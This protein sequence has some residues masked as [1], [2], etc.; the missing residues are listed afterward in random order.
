MVEL[1]LM[2]HERKLL[3]WRLIKNPYECK[4]NV[5]KKKLF[6]YKEDVFDISNVA[7][8]EDIRNCYSE[9]QCK[10]IEND[11]I[12]VPFVNKETYKHCLRLYKNEGDT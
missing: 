12:P 6:E 10:M 11:I 3:V 4:L 5:E 2:P 1:P 8:F 9:M 7:L